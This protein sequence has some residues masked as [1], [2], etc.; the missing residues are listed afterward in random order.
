MKKKMIAMLLAGG[1]LL[2][3][4]IPFTVRSGEPY[5]SIRLPSR[6]KSYGDWPALLT[7]I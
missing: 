2:Y 4:S 6:V 7:V 5:S 1:C 3:T